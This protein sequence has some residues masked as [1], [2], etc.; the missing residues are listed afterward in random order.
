MSAGSDPPRILTVLAECSVRGVVIGGLAA[1]LQGAPVVTT[2]L[3]PV[4]DTAPGNLAR[5]VEALRRVG[6]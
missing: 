3:D 4:V 1:W 6:P 2:E 5:R